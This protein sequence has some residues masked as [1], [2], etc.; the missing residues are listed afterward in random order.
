MTDDVTTMRMSSLEWYV[1]DGRLRLVIDKIET[2]QI[3]LVAID[4]RFP[5]IRTAGIVNMG[6]PQWKA[7]AEII[8]HLVNTGSSD[9]LDAMLST[10]PLFGR[11]NGTSWQPRDK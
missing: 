4:Q 2:G 6:P 1:R 8:L 5:H 11:P 9:D 3:S 7:F 10:M